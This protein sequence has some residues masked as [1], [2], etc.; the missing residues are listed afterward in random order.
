MIKGK[1]NKNWQFHLTK[2]RGQGSL[3]RSAVNQY[4]SGKLRYIYYL[5]LN[6]FVLKGGNYVGAELVSEGTRSVD[7]SF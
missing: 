1:K 7:R 5:R 3:T 2:E 4:P 6:D